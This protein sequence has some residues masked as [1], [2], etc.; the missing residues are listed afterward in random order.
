MAERQGFRAGSWRSGGL[1]AEV[2]TESHLDEKAIFAAVERFAK[3][4]DDRLARQRKAV[5]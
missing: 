2:I 3:D 4:H 5:S 1:E